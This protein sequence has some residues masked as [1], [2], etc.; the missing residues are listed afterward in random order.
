VS[1]EAFSHILCRPRS[2]KKIRCIGDWQL[3]KLNQAG[4]TVIGFVR[5]QPSYLNSHYTQ[6][7]KRFSTAKSLEA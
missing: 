3:K 6:H 1:H 2:A 4:M 5:D 7:V